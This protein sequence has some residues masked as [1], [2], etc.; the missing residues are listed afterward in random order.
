[1]IV[2]IP[3]ALVISILTLSLIGHADRSEANDINAFV[4]SCITAYNW[5]KPLCECVP[6]KAD[7]RLTPNGFA[8]LIAVMNEDEANIAEL[9]DRLDMNERTDA[10]MFFVNAP[11]E[12][13]DAFEGN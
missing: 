5:P 4:K 3:H 11:Q 6:E 8:F 13:G 9:R 10:G 7:E 1:V 2:K 12:C